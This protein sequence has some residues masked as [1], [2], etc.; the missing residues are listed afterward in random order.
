M[1]NTFCT[2][3]MAVPFVAEV[4]ASQPLLMNL[5]RKFDK[6]FNGSANGSYIEVVLPGYGTS[7]VAGHDLTSANL[8][9]TSAA[10]QVSVSQY[11]KGVGLK[12]IE[13][14][15]DL[16]D[17]KTQIA[18]PYGGE[19][20]SDMHTK[21]VEDFMLRAE[22]ATVITSPGTTNGFSDL[23]I[24]VANIRN[25]KLKGQVFGVLS[26][27]LMTK[28]LNSGI[29]Q[30]NPQ[31]IVSD[32]YLKGR[33]GGFRNADWY[34]SSDV[35]SLTAGAATGTLTVKNTVNTDATADYSEIVIAGGTGTLVA[36]DVLKI[37]GAKA[38]SVYGKA[39]TQD[40]AAI[41]QED[42]TLSG[43][44]AVKIQPIFFK[45][46]TGIKPRQNVS[47]TAFTAGVSIT[48]VTA[49]GKTYIR[50]IV[51]AKD[52]GA[53]ASATQ[54]PIVSDFA[55]ANGEALQVLMQKDGS[56]LAGYGYTTWD[57]L[58]GWKV[59]RGNGVSAI[60]WQID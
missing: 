15:L 29:N 44:T 37:A 53:Y 48:R 57:V 14:A 4:E 5:P 20:G 55:P 39:L 26:E 58:C 13:Q 52:A 9:Y 46:A 11:R 43:D 21:A 19:L 45:P 25:A 59:V 2:T 32:M 6:H 49:A 40:F 28:V 54:K 38:V 22:T 18:Q 42:V 10:V 31:A 8:D 36:G 23:G 50:G 3:K 34:S 35:S 33:I 7:A 51:L 47:V 60:L 17:F 30:F 12:A 41:V 27:D 1:S 24:A 56:L 16:A